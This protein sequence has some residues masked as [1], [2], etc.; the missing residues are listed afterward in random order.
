M[1]TNK[2]PLIS[3]KTEQQTLVSSIGMTPIVASRVSDQ[4]SSQASMKV[5]E[6]PEKT[7]VQS[8]SAAI[9]Q[10]PVLP[11]VVLPSVSLPM[12]STSLGVMAGTSGVP[13]LPVGLQHQSVINPLTN[14]GLVGAHTGSYLQPQIAYAPYGKDLIPVLISGGHAAAL[15]TQYALQMQASQAATAL[16]ESGTTTISTAGVQINPSYLNGVVPTR[17]PT[18]DPGVLGRIP[19]SLQDAQMRGLYPMAAPVIGGHPPMDISQ[20]QYLRQIYQQQSLLLQSQ[21]NV[22]AASTTP[23]PVAAVSAVPVSRLGNDAT[24]A[25]STSPTPDEQPLNL[26]KKPTDQPLNLK[27]KRSAETQGSSSIRSSVIKITSSVQSE[28]PKSAESNTIMT[29]PS[30]VPQIFHPSLQIQTP[31]TSIVSP[32]GD[33]Q[34]YPSFI[35]PPPIM[36]PGA[37]PQSVPSAGAAAT[38]PPIHYVN[39]YGLPPQL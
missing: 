10:P 29:M 26:S 12:P 14:L 2:V 19:M 7:P 36:L 38:L 24:R 5:T 27:K 11:P 9:S 33:R 4:S 25:E 37:V 18:I 1:L 39:C 30:T 20:Q 23:K 32:L 22:T 6:S 13:H 8:T 21:N 31:V 35:L 34:V 15:Q 16:K 17:L 28:Q 3:K